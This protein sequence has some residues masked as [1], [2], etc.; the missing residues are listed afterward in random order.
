M[1]ATVN[2]AG[3]RRVVGLKP[4]NT[5]EA[6]M[7]TAGPERPMVVGVII[8][9]NTASPAAATVKWGDGATDYDIISAKSIAANDSWFGEVMIPMLEGWTIKV[10]SGTGSALTFTL[11]LIETGGNLGGSPR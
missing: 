5:S 1:T 4:G 9:N 11:V 3:P 7:L 6:T 2:V 10:T 8:A